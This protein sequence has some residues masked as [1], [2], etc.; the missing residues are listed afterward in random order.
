MSVTA[1]Q[2]P[3]AVVGGGNRP[4]L[5]PVPSKAEQ[6][7]AVTTAKGEAVEGVKEKVTAAKNKRA[8]ATY[9]VARDNLNVAL[10]NTTT[11]YFTGKIPAI[12]AMQQVADNAQKIL[13]PAIKSLVRESGEGVF[14]DRDALDIQAMM[15][16][17]E[18]HPDALPMVQYNIDS[19]IASKL[20]QP[21]P[22]RPEGAI[23]PPP[24]IS[25]DDPRWNQ[26]SNEEK[27]EVIKTYEAKRGNTK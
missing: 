6:E 3:D 4:A 18:T 27:L 17:R 24:E 13:F 5:Q 25:T 8:Y 26:L 16:T 10:K 15:P 12:K 21:L 19:Y 20:G 23:E 1:G 22:P 9:Q 14:T 7:A 11:G 2:S